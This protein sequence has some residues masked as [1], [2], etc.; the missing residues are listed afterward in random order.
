MYRKRVD[1]YERLSAI[2]MSAVRRIEAIENMRRTEASVELIFK[3][4]SGVRN[5]LAR[6]MRVLYDVCQDVRYKECD[7]CGKRVHNT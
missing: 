7:R 4:V 5:A 3:A 2:P 6:A 1:L